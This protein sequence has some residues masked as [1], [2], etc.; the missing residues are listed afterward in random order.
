MPFWPFHLR[1]GWYAIHLCSLHRCNPLP[2]STILS[3]CLSHL[4]SQIS[5][6]VFPQNKQH[7]FRLQ[8]RAAQSPDTSPTPGKIPNLGSTQK[9]QC[10]SQT[11]ASREAV[12]CERNTSGHTRQAQESQTHSSAVSHRSKDHTRK[13]ETKKRTN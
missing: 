13:P 9:G 3:V 5:Y 4:L 12:R 7:L 6:L 8:Q 10:Q 11:P 1:P 2:S